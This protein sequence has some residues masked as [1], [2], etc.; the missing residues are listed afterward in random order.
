MLGSLFC[1]LVA[2]E[3]SEKGLTRLV[4]DAVQLSS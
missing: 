3:G 4:D 1:G 2:L